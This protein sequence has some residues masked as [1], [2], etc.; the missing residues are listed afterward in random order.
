MPGRQNCWAQALCCGWPL[1]IKTVKSCREDSA[2]HLLLNAFDV[3]VFSPFGLDFGP[4]IAVARRASPLLVGAPA[5]RQRARE[6]LRGRRSMCVAG[7]QQC[8]AGA[9][10]VR[11]HTLVSSTSQQPSTC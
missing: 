6:G 10:G 7:V 8:G 2:P 11:G 5:N 4:G 3:V 9:E 1:M